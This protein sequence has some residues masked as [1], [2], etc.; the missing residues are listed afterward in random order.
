MIADRK[1]D[2]FKVINY[3]LSYYNSWELL[4]AKDIG[5][6]YFQQSETG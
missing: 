6:R 5:V 2:E 4:I 3:G 1:W